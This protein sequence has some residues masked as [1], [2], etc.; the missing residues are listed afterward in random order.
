[1]TRARFVV[2][3][4]EGTWLGDLSRDLPDTTVRLRAGLGTEQ[5]AVGL[6][7][8]TAPDIDAVLAAIDAHPEVETVGVFDRT[9]TEAVVQFET[10]ESLLLWPALA[11]GVPVEFP[12][13][14][15]EGEAVLDVV[16]DPDRI[17]ALAEMLDTR[18]AAF[19]IEYIRDDDHSTRLTRTQCE[20]L[21]AAL[22]EGYY[23]TPRRCSLTDLADEVGLAKSTVSETLHRAEGVVVRSFLRTVTPDRSRTEGV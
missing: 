23:D 13:E 8:L 17:T 18:A 5:K 16:G 3:L 9:D 22:E 4:P 21:R 19:T 20:L 14:I 1:M 12:V 7:W 15:I 2:S 10:D 11:A 6:C